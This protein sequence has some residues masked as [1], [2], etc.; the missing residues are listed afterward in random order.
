MKHPMVT[1]VV[2]TYQHADYITE[3]L[4]G[5]VNQRTSFPIHA[6]VVD[7]ASTDGTTEIVAEY[8][9]RYPDIIEAVLLKENMYHLAIKTQQIVLPRLKG[10]YIAFCEGDDYWTEP[11]KLQQQVDFLER[12]SDYSACFHLHSIRNESDMQYTN[13]V[14][15]HKSRRVAKRE[16]I[17]EHLCHTNSILFRREYYYNR[18]LWDIYPK[19]YPFTDVLLFAV[20]A[21][22]GKI[23]GFNKYWSVYRLHEGGVCTS[24]KLKTID[25][26]YI[27]ERKLIDLYYG[28]EHSMSR[29]MG[30]YERLEKWTRLRRSG[31]YRAAIW[32]LFQA[33][34]YNPAGFMRLYIS[35]YLL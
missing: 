18:K 2:M 33:A 22:S 32:Q 31:K 25:T 1:V 24:A 12:H 14:A 16:M 27:M 10:K 20:L 17:I 11:D 35:R 23:W 4:E 9:R 26:T 28:R 15:M 6:L 21:D 8:A 5:I 29:W 13:K 3:C 34:L 30:L 19:V 7:D